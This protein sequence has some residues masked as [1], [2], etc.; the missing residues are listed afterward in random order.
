MGKI[1]KE[2]VLEFHGKE[3]LEDKKLSYADVEKN[4][5]SGNLQYRTI[6]AF[7]E[8]NMG[9]AKVDTAAQ[10]AL[11]MG[12]SLNRL[13]TPKGSNWTDADT[14]LSKT[15]FIDDNLQI[16]FAYLTKE[17]RRKLALDLINAGYEKLG[18]L[19]NQY[20]IETSIVDSVKNEGES[21]G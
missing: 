4:C 21:N 13:Y 10:I 1:E 5:V 2:T 7:F 17:A 14:E 6:Y 16:V 15:Q 20:A 8:T 3:L 9:K 18:E 11:A 12:T 19:C